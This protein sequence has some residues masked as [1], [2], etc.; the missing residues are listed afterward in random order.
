MLWAQVA[1][2][3]CHER[4]PLGG[5]RVGIRPHKA[6][7]DPTEV[8]AVDPQAVTH[9]LAD[10]QQVLVR[11]RREVF[12]AEGHRPGFGNE[13][14]RSCH[15]DGRRCG[16]DARRVVVACLAASHG[17]QGQEAKGDDILVEPSGS[18]S[19]CFAPPGRYG[20]KR[21]RHKHRYSASP[22]VD[23]V[24]WGRAGRHT[25]LLPAARHSDSPPHRCAAAALGYRQPAVAQSGPGRDST[26]AREVNCGERRTLSWPDLRDH[27]PNRPFAS[28]Q[29][30][31][32]E[33]SSPADPLH[34]W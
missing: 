4:P 32:L 24:R 25:P 18:F 19:H 3:A 26:W 5:C 7:D 30:P 20:S 16:G 17:Q 9:K 23:P 11:G 34:C 6:L 27:N 31:E 33:G 22:E 1:H 14:C 12:G 15:G 21:Q 2:R 10:L 29:L 8:E 13:C 28:S